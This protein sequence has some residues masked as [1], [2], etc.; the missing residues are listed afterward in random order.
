[1]RRHCPRCGK[2]TAI[3]VTAKTHESPD[4]GKIIEEEWRCEDCF[5]HFK[6][7]SPIWDGFW[8]VA[9]IAFLVAAVGCAA[10]W[11]KAQENQRTM[12]AVLLFAMAAGAGLYGV[13]CLRTRSKAPPV[14]E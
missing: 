5:K 10:G 7:H 11:F 6:L 9:G 14:K 3:V 4:L 1:M 13:S 12:I 8:I 2:P